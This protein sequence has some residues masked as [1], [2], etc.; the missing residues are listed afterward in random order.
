[1]PFGGHINV[2]TVHKLPK[3]QC[4]VPGD[5]Y[6]IHKIIIKSFCK[7]AAILIAIFNWRRVHWLDNGRF[8]CMNTRIHVKEHYEYDS[9]RWCLSNRLCVFNSTAST[10]C[11]SYSILVIF[12]YVIPCIHLL[13]F[14]PIFLDEIPK[15]ISQCNIIHTTREHSHISRWNSIP[16]GMKPIEHMWDFSDRKPSNVNVWNIGG[17]RNVWRYQISEP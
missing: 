4:C 10:K 17:L 12:I 2:W 7:L 9:V 5:P 15:P 3:A 16:P 11:T 1:M 8:R 14:I 13:S 6:T